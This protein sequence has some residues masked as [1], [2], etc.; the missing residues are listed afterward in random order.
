M[1]NHHTIQKRIGIVASV[2]LLLCASGC[3]T[4][5]SD[6]PGALRS[7]LSAADTEV[8]GR[9]SVEKNHWFFLFGLIGETPK[10]MFSE[11]LKAQVKAAG[12]DGMSN[13]KY[14]SIRSC[15]DMAISYFTCNILVPQS[16]MVSGD[17]VRIR[18]SALPGTPLALS[19]ESTTVQKRIA[20]N[21]Q[22]Y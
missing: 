12:G 21:T 6:L 11:D 3:L 7:D 14:E 1:K 22:V 13:V 9:A 19:Q 20:D 4:M 2:V 18:K 10:D 5:N 15:G 8:I 16:Y 17:I